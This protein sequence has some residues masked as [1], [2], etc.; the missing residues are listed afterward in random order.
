MNLVC[1]QGWFFCWQ[2]EERWAG[3][4]QWRNQS[5]S[6][7]PCHALPI[8]QDFNHNH[9]LTI[10][11]KSNQFC[12]NHEKFQNKI[13]VLVRIFFAGCS[14]SFWT[15]DKTQMLRRWLMF[16]RRMTSVTHV[17]LSALV[18]R[19]TPPVLG[20]VDILAIVLQPLCSSP[21]RE[22]YIYQKVL[23]FEKRQKGSLEK[24]DRSWSSVDM[25]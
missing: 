14:W 25:V 7:P 18:S 6:S 16:L 8:Y 12:F 21:L 4:W 17:A 22:C 13:L 2:S 11:T 1:Q 9:Q 10:F 19:R 20:N 24:D 5:A 15:G 3:V 23:L